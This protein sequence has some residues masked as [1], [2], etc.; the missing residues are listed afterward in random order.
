LAVTI[1]GAAIGFTILKWKKKVIK[2]WL[3]PNLKDGPT[4][5]LEDGILQILLT[6]TETIAD[7]PI[8]TVHYENLFRWRSE[9]LRGYNNLYN[10]FARALN[11]SAK[12]LTGKD[13]IGADRETQLRILDKTYQIRMSTGKLNLVRFGIFERDWILFD[14]YIIR[15]ILRLFIRT[16]AWIMLGYESWPGK[17]RRLRRYRVAPGKIKLKSNS[18]GRQRRSYYV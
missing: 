15:D 8:D 17:V 18:L 11:S 4:D 12:R 13:F 10:K 7:V 9:N 2:R 3:M 16:D 1:G 6:A 14:R 5:K